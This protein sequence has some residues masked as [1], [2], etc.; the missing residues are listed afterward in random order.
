MKEV[1]WWK[2]ISEIDQIFVSSKIPAPQ[3]GELI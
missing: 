3:G 1:S 2:Y